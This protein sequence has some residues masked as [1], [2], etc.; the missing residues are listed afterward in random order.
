MSE[1]KGNSEGSV[2]R[3][4][5][6][7]GSRDA[8]AGFGIWGF[9]Q[10]QISLPSI[11]WRSVFAQREN[12]TT[13]PEF[14]F[15][16]NRF[17]ADLD[18]FTYNHIEVI[19]TGIKKFGKDFE[20]QLR[21]L[22]Y[23]EGLWNESVDQCCA[24]LGRIHEAYVSL[25]QKN[26][27]GDPAE[28][29]RLRD[30][31][32]ELAS[33]MWVIGYAGEEWNNRKDQLNGEV[34]LYRL[35]NFR[36]P[37]EGD[38]DLLIG[39]EI[40]NIHALWAE[41]GWKEMP[42]QNSHGGLV[43]ISPVIELLTSEKNPDDPDRPRFVNGLVS[44]TKPG[45]YRI[46]E[47]FLADFPM[48]VGINALSGYQR[49]SNLDEASKKAEGYN[50]AVGRPRRAE[51][52]GLDP[53]VHDFLM[54]K[55]D[56]LGISRT[57]AKIIV[58]RELANTPPGVGAMG[59]FEGRNRDIHILSELLKK[60]DLEKYLQL[61]LRVVTHEFGHAISWL[62]RRLPNPTEAQSQIVVIRS[63]LSVIRAYPQTARVFEADEEREPFTPVPSTNTGVNLPKEDAEARSLNRTF[64]TNYA[65]SVLLNEGL[66]LQVNEW[67][68]QMSLAGLTKMT[69][70]KL[71]VKSGIPATRRLGQLEV[72]N[73]G[74]IPL[75]TFHNET[76]S[77]LVF[78]QYR[79]KDFLMQKQYGSFSAFYHDLRQNRE[80]VMPP[81]S[82]EARIMNHIEENLGQYDHALQRW[83]YPLTERGD[84]ATG[85]YWLNFFFNAVIPTSLAD[86]SVN[87]PQDLEK[88]LKE[89]ADKT[90][91][92][93]QDH[94]SHDLILHGKWV[95]QAMNMAD[96]E[97][98][99][100]FFSAIKRWKDEGVKV[101]DDISWP[102]L[103]KRVG[104][105][106]K[107]LVANGVALKETE[108]FHI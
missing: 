60:G 77:G 97:R 71:S 65:T 40:L 50:K 85:D 55:L 37:L 98:W 58:E 108:T 49:D 79:P 42:V 22:G 48:E 70:Q 67:W 47:N 10:P 14:K 62:V 36:N 64:L 13:Q 94:L 16:D 21:P 76:F 15:A 86:L 7:T 26:L 9:A 89:G 45:F 5:F 11:D 24:V 61:G 68:R 20:A 31:F 90:K 88:R 17:Y 84:E 46:A 99:A 29:E 75:I 28:K 93:A 66:Y 100:D 96:E 63:M 2:S 107:V 18:R 12:R 57:V 54:Q 53:Q 4:A 69:L 87:S 52:T 101:A 72:T 19:R 51:L 73:Q 35:N 83:F 82:F 34:S 43:R 6:L 41:T 33:A 3:R 92:F 105:I 38:T 81:N 44:S 25:E 59:Y 102:E 80:S 1:N 106:M 27:L 39:R 23:E 32:Y 78:R 8:A 74:G 104:E 56:E 91:D 95:K 103:E 30:C